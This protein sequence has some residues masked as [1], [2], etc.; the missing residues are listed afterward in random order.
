MPLGDHLGMATEQLGLRRLQTRRLLDRATERN[1]LPEGTMSVGLGLVISGIATYGF[2]SI[3][4]RA[5][6]EDAFAPVSLLWFLT[7][8]L[9][10]GFFL[11][12]E[13]EVGR[14]L[15][16]RRALGQGSR[17]VVERAAVLEGILLVTITVV[18]L[19]ISPLLVT[20]LFEDSWALFFGLLIAFWSYALAHL[21][22]GIWSGTGRFSAYALL[23]GSEGVFRML[24]AIVL[25]VVGVKAVGPYGILVGLPAVAAVLLSRRGQ[26]DVLEPGPEAS[27]NELTPNLGWLLA[28]SVF[29]AA[30]LNAG[31]IAASLLKSS[32][33]EN[34]LVSQLST[35][36]II[37]RVPLFL[38]QAVQAALLPKLARLAARGALDDFTRGF[39]KLMKLVLVVGVLAIVASFA[40]GPFAVKVFFD[41][42]LSRRTLTMLALASALYMVALALAQA[43]I[44][45]R[46]HAK[47]A[48]GWVVGMVAFVAVAAI[49]DDDLLLRVEL[50][51]VAGSVA[52]LVVF[53]AVLRNL[54]HTGVQPDEDSIREALDTLPMEP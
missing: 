21:T 19:A 12:V 41:S 42:E 7:F 52:S 29:A 35:G 45:L 25:A 22:R 54:M 14:A 28:G 6:G 44:A 31:P 20:H 27:W 53:A 16:H 18:M 23:M 13:Q 46:G 36:V 37:A 9:A 11:P 8:I 24:A 50:A 1:P 4:K 26:R 3:T 15:A 32:S 34:S 38:F 43:I 47:V 39:R 40:A 51:L 5:L 2:L 10:P 30:L 17:P 48:F 33:A 49:P